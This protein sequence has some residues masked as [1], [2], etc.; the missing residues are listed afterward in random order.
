MKAH[1]CTIASEHH[2]MNT[3]AAHCP[4][5]NEEV[6]FSDV[7]LGE[8]PHC[9]TKICVPNRYYRPASIA[10]CA[11]TILV[12]A[13]TGGLVWTSPA[14]FSYVML[15]MFLMLMT[16]IVAQVVFIRVWIVISPPQFDQI[17]A[18]D[19]VTRLRLDD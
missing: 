14:V 13:K 12:I 18:N 5:C 9:H 1:W 7:R 11:F 17:H 16:F 3:M 8:C 19:A 6:P 10:A 2:E 4:Q 15:W